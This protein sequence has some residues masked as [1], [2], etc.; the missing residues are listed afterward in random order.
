MVRV[1]GSDAPGVRPADPELTVEQLAGGRPM[2]DPSACPLCGGELAPWA[3]PEDRAWRCAKCG[4]LHFEG[5]VPVDAARERALVDYRPAWWGGATRE[6]VRAFELS[7]CAC[8]GGCRDNPPD[9][10]GIPG[11]DD[12][13]LRRQLGV[14]EHRLRDRRRR[15]QWLIGYA[16]ALLRE[17]EARDAAS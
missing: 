2:S 6:E 8:G 14:A 13:E 9:G 1:P 7:E 4:R 12:R 3:R 15:S 16:E 17:A 10:S 11:L 5:A